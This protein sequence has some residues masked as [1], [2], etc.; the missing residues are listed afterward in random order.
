MSRCPPPLG[1]T[2][3]G[4]RSSTCR[5]SSPMVSVLPRQER[6]RPERCERSV[7]QGA[8]PV[9]PGEHGG[10]AWGSQWGT[11]GRVGYPASELVW[12]SG[13]GQRGVG[14]GAGDQHG[15]RTVPLPGLP[16]V[17]GRAD[18]CPRGLSG[19]VV[20]VISA[21][22]GSAWERGRQ[23]FSFISLLSSLAVL[24]PVLLQQEACWHLLGSFPALFPR[25]ECPLTQAP[26]SPGVEHSGGSQLHLWP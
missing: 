14:V 2:C 9:G 7:K 17:S 15:C 8:G 26:P 3:W 5:A 12:E 22:P 20:P 16:A 6:L 24:L 25:Q 13:Q 1:P 18:R 4:G 10:A 11:W 21:T 23:W 19:T